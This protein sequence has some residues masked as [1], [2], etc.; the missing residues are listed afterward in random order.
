MKD[1]I[2]IHDRKINQTPDHTPHKYVKTP[3][4]QM[5]MLYSNDNNKISVGKFSP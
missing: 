4:S 2:K 5:K 1:N 3:T